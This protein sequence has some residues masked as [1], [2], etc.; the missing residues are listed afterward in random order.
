MIEIIACCTGLLIAKAE[1]MR[2]SK[3]QLD[4]PLW[5]LSTALL[6][7]MLV[8]CLA[9][10]EEELGSDATNTKLPVAATCTPGD[11]F[12]GSPVVAP[13]SE[14]TW[15][16]VPETRCRD[17]S[18]TGFAVRINP[19][20]DKL[21]IYLQGGGACFN[22]ASCLANPSSFG[23][24]KFNNW[25]DDKGTA[26]ILDDSK[27][28]N[29]VKDWNAV[30]IPYCTGDVHTGN[31]TG[32]NVPGLLGPNNQAF[33]GYANLG[34]DL[35]RIVPTFP[36]L[37]KVLLTGDSAGGFGALFNYDRVAQ[38][39][40]PADVS[41]IDD[42]GLILPDQYL[43]PCL[44]ER[45]RSLWKLSDNLPQDCE[46]CRNPDGGGLVNMYTFLGAK[47][48]TS[49]LGAL[50]S[51]ADSIITLFYGWGRNECANINGL[52][53]PLG[54]GRY[55]EGLQVTRDSYLKRSPAWGSYYINSLQHTW[56]GGNSYYR[57]KV[58]GVTLLSWVRDIVEG[59]PSKHVA[60]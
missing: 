4:I 6:S 5:A 17:G 7:S 21:V 47:Y 9:S 20:S 12:D 26:G 45:W 2:I 11:S 8:G 43:A 50:G 52:D 16:P 35:E 54:I 49:R 19:A 31:A 51:R 33:V 57:N 24:D 30:F 46:G 53:A 1:I 36:N 34:H 23:I 38:A 60:P 48:P 37:S 14:W 28:T 18:T 39:F 3:T 40:C 41:L 58:K 10:G 32:V 13:P 56:I 44:Q 55:A 42:S 27:D 25:K 22:G 15:V 59:A 29:P